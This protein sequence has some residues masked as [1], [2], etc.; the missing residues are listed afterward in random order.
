ML[1]LG[2]IKMALAGL[3]ARPLNGH[4]KGVVVHLLG[5]VKVGRVTVILIIGDAG[6]VSRFSGFF[7]QVVIVVIISALYLVR[8]GGG[9]PEKPGGKRDRLGPARRGSDKTNC[10]DYK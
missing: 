3:N 10:R 1:N 5:Q 4:A 8:A 7:P 2:V 6:H 9:S